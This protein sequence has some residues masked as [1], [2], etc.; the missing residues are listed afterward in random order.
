[1]P[2]RPIEDL[3]AEELENLTLH[4]IRFRE[5]WESPRPRRREQFTLTSSASKVLS[6]YFLPGNDHRY[7]ISSGYG[8]KGQF[9]SVQ[10]WDLA[11]GTPYCAGENR[12]VGTAISLAVN[13]V[14]SH[15]GAI[16]LSLQRWWAYNTLEVRILSDGEIFRTDS[17]IQILQV[18]PTCNEHTGSLNRSLCVAAEL[19]FYGRILCLHGQ[20]LVLELPHK[21]L[22]LYDWTAMKK[23]F[24]LQ[25]SEDVVLFFLSSSLSHSN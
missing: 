10:L 4:A 15:R 2:N 25:A 24:T 20:Y 17:I 9:Y 13:S 21:L 22:A 7:L 18:N 14:A 5:N 16:A 19:P 6:L 1:M 12:V 23:L 8:P 11:C 3:S